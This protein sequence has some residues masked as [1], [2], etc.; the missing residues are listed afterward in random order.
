MS[1]LKFIANKNKIYLHLILNKI[2]CLHLYI[3]KFK[4]YFSVYLKINFS[5]AV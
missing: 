1:L 2:T 3:K 4:I 5:F